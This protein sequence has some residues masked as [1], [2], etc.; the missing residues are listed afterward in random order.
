MCKIQGSVYNENNEP[1][2]DDFEVELPEE[3]KAKVGDIYQLGA[4]RLI[5]GDATIISDV[6][7]LMDGA[8]ADLVVTDPP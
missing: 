6:E 2:E 8:Q 1:V 7:K 4:H 5:C 3:P